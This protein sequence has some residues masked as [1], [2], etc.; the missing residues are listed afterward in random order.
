VLGTLDTPSPD[1][2]AGEPVSLAPYAPAAIPTVLPADDP[3]G[4]WRV[5][6]LVLLIAGAVIAFGGLLFTVQY[7]TMDTTVHSDGYYYSGRVHNIGLISERQSGLIVSVVV[8]VLGAAT[9]AVGWL[10]HVYASQRR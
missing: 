5:S 9:M 7:A 1:S 4:T 10:T 6:E 2:P 8:L 3:D